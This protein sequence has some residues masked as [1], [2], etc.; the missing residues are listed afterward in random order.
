MPTKIFNL[1][2]Q[3]QR[4]AYLLTDRDF[5]IISCGGEVA[6][7][8]LTNDQPQD[9]LNIIPELIGSED[10]LL[11]VLNGTLP[12]FDLEN[13]NR[14]D[15]K[16]ETVYLNLHLQAYQAETK[17]A[18]L[19]V[20]ARDTSEWA[21]VQRTL[22]QQRN[23]LHL[24]QH[25]LLQTNEQLEFIL[26]HYVPREVSKGIMEKRIVPELGGELREISVLFADLRNYTS[27][28]EQLT[29]RETVEMLHV[30][31]DLAS[32]AVAKTGGVIVNYMGDALMA[33]FNAPTNQPDHAYQAVQAGLLMQQ[34]AEEYRKSQAV[35]PPMYFGVGINTGQALVGNIGAH[36]HYQ[37]TAVGDNVN[38]ASRIC[39]YA[40]AGEVLI[41]A[42]PYKKL[43]SNLEVE[44]LEPLKFKGKSQEIM[45][46]R[47][48]KTNLN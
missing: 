40:R 31:L 19:L 42:N 13:I 38:V 28:S 21:K 23:E 16:G 37:Y 47:I 30:Y 48:I 29:P 1:L 44:P 22:T 9:L 27:I 14:V 43:P 39:S 11:E 24:L 41:G 17:T 46:Y 26:Q 15:D 45:V 3:E 20:V 32:A 12:N 5:H 35:I 7:C 10:I 2:L 18:E 6:G 25:H 4:I 8:L 33:V 34:N 36:W